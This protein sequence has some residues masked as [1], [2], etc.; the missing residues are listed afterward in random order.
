MTLTLSDRVYTAIYGNIPQHITDARDE[1]LNAKKRWQWAQK[2][3]RRS[4]DKDSE[5]TQ[6][7]H[8]ERSEAFQQMRD[9]VAV[10]NAFS[11]SLARSLFRTPL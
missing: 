8:D 5:W 7:L 10:I 9:A 6:M 11:P 3:L 1:V 4:N 2:E